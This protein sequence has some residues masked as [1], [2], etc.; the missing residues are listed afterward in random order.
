[1]E[2]HQMPWRAQVPFKTSLNSLSDF[3]L[4][5]LEMLAPSLM[6]GLK[7]PDFDRFVHQAGQTE[8]LGMKGVGCVFIEEFMPTARQKRRGRIV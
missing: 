1:M 8:Q 4:D 2:H 7:V 3:R 5:L 6:V